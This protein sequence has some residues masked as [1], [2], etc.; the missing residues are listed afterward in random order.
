MKRE[1][2]GVTLVRV[3]M[4]SRVLL[5]LALS[6]MTLLIIAPPCFGTPAWWNY[7]V[8]ES[9]SNGPF[10]NAA[11]F[12]KGI[13]GYTPAYGSMSNYQGK[14]NSFYIWHRN[15]QGLDNAVE[16]GWSWLRPDQGNAPMLF[17]VTL[18]NHPDPGWYHE[19][20][21]RWFDPGSMHKFG[22]GYMGPGGSGQKW[23]CWMDDVY[24]GMMSTTFLAGGSALVGGERSVP[25]PWWYSPHV[26]ECSGNA[27][28]YYIRSQRNDQSGWDY[29][30]ANRDCPTFD[31]D[32]GFKYIPTAIP[33]YPYG[34]HGYIRAGLG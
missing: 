27:E 31:T 2:E 8:C 19:W 17:M 34:P 4:K 1:A 16:V 18:Q 30:W 20:N 22:T 13:D 28:F 25:S 23:G 15:A 21:V 32:G 9:G 26:I 11:Y 24:Y 6:I 14:V 29:W 10:M 12:C 7:S 33:G 3:Q 5:V